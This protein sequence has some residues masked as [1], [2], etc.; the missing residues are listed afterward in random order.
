MVR[1]HIDMFNE[2]ILNKIIFSIVFHAMAKDPVP[3]YPL[4]FWRNFLVSLISWFGAVRISRLS[5]AELAML[6]YGDV[7]CITLLGTG[8]KLGRGLLQCRNSEGHTTSPEKTKHTLNETHH[9][10]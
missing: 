10:D 7:I 4:V 9:N 5:N 8:H 2:I 1:L 6:I 3:F